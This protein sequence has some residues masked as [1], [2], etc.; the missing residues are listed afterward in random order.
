M[1]CDSHCHDG[2]HSISLGV[3][4]FKENYEF[5][6]VNKVWKIH[7]QIPSFFECFVKCMTIPYKQVEGFV[8]GLRFSLYEMYVT[9][10]STHAGGKMVWGLGMN[11]AL[12]QK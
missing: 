3:L 10:Y 6:K 5:V 2:G 1:C 12:Q 7:N 11:S 4:W 9:R 8:K